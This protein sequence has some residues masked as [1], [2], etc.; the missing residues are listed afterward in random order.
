[1]TKPKEGSSDSSLLASPVKCAHKK[2]IKH[3][4]KKEKG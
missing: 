3:T 1:M 4:L 2:N